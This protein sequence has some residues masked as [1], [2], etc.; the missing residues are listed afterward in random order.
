MSRP[1]LLALS[2][3]FLLPV[4]PL[5][6]SDTAP[7]EARAR[8]RTY[9][10][11]DGGR[12]TDELASAARD[13]GYFCVRCHGEDG[14]S[15]MPLVPNL[16]G[17][18]AYYLLEQI[19]RFAS[20]ERNDHIMTPLARQLAPDDRALLAFYYAS[21]RPRPH[22]IE[23]TLKERGEARYR[24]VCVA[25]HGSDARGGERYARLASQHPEYLRRRL[26]QF[27]ARTDGEGSVM[28][29]IARTLSD[30]DISVIAA[31]LASLP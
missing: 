18:N 29:G 9:L 11:A 15:R 14:V 22:A 8:L 5:E 21:Q 28:T 10:A 2:F 12:L 3:V 30:E 31:Y 7:D 16:A 17:Q 25:C 26:Y 24:Q 27:Q 13:R 20:G 1:G 23:A 19:E 6:A 4:A